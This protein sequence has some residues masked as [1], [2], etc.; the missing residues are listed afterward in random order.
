[1]GMA[2]A[3]GRQCPWGGG[4]NVLRREV[5]EAVGGYDALTYTSGADRE[6][7]CRFEA[8]TPYR[9]VYAPDAVIWHIAR[10]SCREFFRNSAKYA[11]DAVVNAQYDPALA[12]YQRGYVRRNLFYI[13]R[14]MAGFVVRSAKWLV[15]CDTKERVAQTVF[16]TA[17]S[18]GGIYGTFKGHRRLAQA[19]R[20]ARGQAMM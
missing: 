1:K 19:K 7:H 11:S 6:F 10:G 8:A 16:W 9:T 2:T 20:D 14:N 17:Q 5:I 12:A 3:D 15:G 18:L 4:N 13:L